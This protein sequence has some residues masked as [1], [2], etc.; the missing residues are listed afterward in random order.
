VAPLSSTSSGDSREHLER[1]AVTARGPKGEQGEQGRRGERGLSRIQGRAVVV[2]FLIAALIG[3]GNLFWTGHSVNAE[4]GKWCSLIVTLD[5]AN[6]AA[7]KKPAAGTFTAA[8]VSEIHQ[9]R[10]EL[11]CA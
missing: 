4:Q 7:P 6:A 3:I 5:Q 1:M 10:Q 2:L 9:L 8:L 11:G